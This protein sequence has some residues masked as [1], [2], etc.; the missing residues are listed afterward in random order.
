MKKTALCCAF[1]AFSA[2]SWSQQALVLTEDKVRELA[3]GA[4]NALQETRAS[5][6]ASQA[7]A[8]A[9]ASRKKPKWSCRP[10]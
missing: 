8:A 6:A 10:T 1:F 2:L 3:V 5:A 7:Q 9:V 4:S